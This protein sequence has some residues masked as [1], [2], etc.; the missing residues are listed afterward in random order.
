MITTNI[1]SYNAKA[2]DKPIFTWL[3]FINKMNKQY[4]AKAHHLQSHK[5]RECQKKGG[6]RE[7]ESVCEIHNEKNNPLTIQQ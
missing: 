4:M 1:E 2:R 7:R 5:S 3:Q 6:K